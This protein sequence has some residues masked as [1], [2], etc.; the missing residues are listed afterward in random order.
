MRKELHVQQWRETYLPLP[1]HKKR[2]KD[3]K[4]LS[5][6]PRRRGGQDDERAISEGEK[7]PS[8]NQPMQ[9]RVSEKKK[10]D[11]GEMNFGSDA[12]SIIPRFRH[13]SGACFPEWGKRSPTGGKRTTKNGE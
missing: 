13:W 8:A 6:S 7:Y 4:P 9:L 11:Q 2:G 3:E 1:Q 5:S 10:P 12:C